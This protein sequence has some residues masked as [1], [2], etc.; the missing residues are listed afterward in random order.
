MATITEMIE[1]LE[2]IGAKYISF[3][4]NHMIGRA[5]NP[6]LLSIR[7][8]LARQI[9]DVIQSG[10][11]VRICGL[12]GM[13]KTSIFSQAVELLGLECFYFHTYL[14]ES[15]KSYGAFLELKKFL[16]SNYPGIEVT[17]KEITDHRYGVFGWLN[18][19]CIK[20][21]RTI[22]IGFDEMLGR[23]RHVVRYF[24]RLPKRLRRLRFVFIDHHNRF[25]R[26][27]NQ[28]FKNTKTFYPPLLNLEETGRLCRWLLA[29][30]NLEITD[31][32][33]PVIH[34]L[35]AGR[36]CEVVS[37]LNMLFSGCFW[38]NNKLTF[39]EVIGNRI[40]TADSLEKLRDQFFLHSIVY[41]EFLDYSLKIGANLT[42]LNPGELGLLFRIADG[43]Q[44]RKKD[45]EHVNYLEKLGI[46]FYDE[47]YWVINGYIL[48]RIID[49]LL[50][51][52]SMLRHYSR[53]NDQSR[54]LACF[55]YE[56]NCFRPDA[57]LAKSQ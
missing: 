56:K 35:T 27:R 15:V 25:D 8:E 26:Y 37:V 50:T 48:M 16:E 29:Q 18:E 57:I 11:P 31:D 14:E 21:N 2:S 5:D 22:I 13:G 45:C 32:A 47:G 42:K 46:L 10:K 30:A 19:L 43:G 7:M 36:P 38:Q 3:S 24:A 17:Q 9:A 4:T 53:K 23:D 39:E 1:Y 41:S 6:P 54:K 28:L 33:L 20:Q 55:D 40:I 49:Y 51:D 52:E 12:H 44:P 34:D